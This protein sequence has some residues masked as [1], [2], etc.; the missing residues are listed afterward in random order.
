MLKLDA[1]VQEPVKSVEWRNGF[2]LCPEDAT[3]EE[4]NNIKIAYL[5]CMEEFVIAEGNKAA[6]TTD[7]ASF[8]S[9]GYQKFFGD[10]S[11]GLI[12]DIEQF[13]EVTNPV[14]FDEKRQDEDASVMIVEDN[15]NADATISQGVGGHGELLAL[16]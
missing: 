14:Q 13:K 2:P 8:R 5:M 6:V 16:N 12:E 4:V 15:T 3:I 9:I 1:N 7:E 11:A 10:K